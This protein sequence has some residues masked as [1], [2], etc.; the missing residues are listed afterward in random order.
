MKFTKLQGA[1]NDYL[2][3]D[4]REIQ[5]DWS[6]LAISMSDRHFGVGSDGIIVA[7]NSQKAPIRMQMF[8]ADGSEAEMCGN[9]I[10]C[11]AKLIFDANIC[12]STSMLIDTGAGPLKVDM[13]ST[14]KRV[15]RIKVDMGLPILENTK[16]PQ[17][18]FFNIAITKQVNEYLFC[19][20]TG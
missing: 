1:G 19:K 8:N 18:A 10:R 15:D 16:I 11:V 20:F 5:E 9:G 3:L 4:G 13:V 2:F 7:R 17:N 14:G 12:Q 6:S